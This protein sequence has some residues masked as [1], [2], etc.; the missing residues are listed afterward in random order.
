MIDLEHFLLQIKNMVRNSFKVNPYPKRRK[1]SMRNSS[2]KVG[3]Y[4]DTISREV[5]ATE[6]SHVGKGMRRKVRLENGNLSIWSWIKGKKIGI[7]SIVCCN[8]VGKLLIVHTS[9]G[10]CIILALKYE[11]MSQS[12]ADKIGKYEI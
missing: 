11:F 9:D 4:N 8:Y 1:F 3:P 10:D 5:V 2:E 12:I 6:I 7:E